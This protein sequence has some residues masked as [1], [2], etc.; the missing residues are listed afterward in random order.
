[1]QHVTQKKEDLRILRTRD[2]IYRCFLEMRR[3]KSIEDIRIT[4]LCEKAGINRATF[5]HHYQDIYALSDELEYGVI[6]RYQQN[7]NENDIHLFFHEPSQFLAHL[8]EVIEAE[9]ETINILSSGRREI[10]FSKMEEKLVDFLMNGSEDEELRIQLTFA[11]GGA[12][13][14]IYVYSSDRSYQTEVLSTK[15]CDMVLR[16]VEE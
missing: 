8:K 6:D 10:M 3:K 7:L 13:H 9:K 16:V 1:M 4:E 12:I 5:Y 15:I 14:V 2:K 11:I